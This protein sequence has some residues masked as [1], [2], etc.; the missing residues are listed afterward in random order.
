[1]SLF[2]ALQYTA[3]YPANISPRTTHQF[4]RICMQWRQPLLTGSTYIV[5][6]V[7]FLGASLCPLSMYTWSFCAA[8]DP[9]DP[10]PRPRLP[11]PLQSTSD[12]SRSASSSETTGGERSRKATPLLLSDLEKELKKLHSGKNPLVSAA[13]MKPLL[14]WSDSAPRGMR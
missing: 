10:P 8:A 1:M 12:V 13:G 7:R 11:P 3:F 6:S 4:V 14:S 5:V 2:N 9:A